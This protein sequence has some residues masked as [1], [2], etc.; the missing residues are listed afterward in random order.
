MS[1]TEKSAEAIVAKS[2]PAQAHKPGE[3]GS[4]RRS[5]GPNGWKGETPASLGGA[6]HQK[7]RQ[8]GLPLAGRG[9]APE[10]QR[11]GGAP[12]A[13]SG[14]ERS[15]TDRLMEQV[16]E[17]ANAKAA[18]KRVRQNKGS[19]GPDG[20]TVEELPRYLVEKWEEIRGQRDSARI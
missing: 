2:K 12:T 17:R 6:R 4:L 10:V 7:P 20:M 18:L 9:E 16:V 3:V 8:L 14:N 15:G 11:S 5:E 13:A 1:R 19:P